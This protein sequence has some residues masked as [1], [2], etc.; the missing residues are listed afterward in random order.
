MAK[1]LKTIICRDIESRFQDMEGCVLVDYRGLNAEQTQDLRATLREGGVSMSVIRNR[2]ARRVFA[3]QGLDQQFQ[4]LLRGPTA[5]LLGE[6]GALSASRSLVQWSQKNKDLVQIKGGLFQGKALSVDDVE[7][8]ARIPD[9]ETLQ[10]QLRSIFLS[11]ASFIA[12][13]TRNLLSHFASATKAH[14]ETLEG[15]GG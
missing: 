8:L 14:R 4:D 6:D 9:R 15:D 3:E 5:V 13:A 10:S 7:R 11:P 12:S 1:E 2:L